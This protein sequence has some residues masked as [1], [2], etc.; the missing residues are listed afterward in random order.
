MN[1]KPF[2]NDKTLW[3]DFLLELSDRKLACY[4]KLEQLTDPVDIYRTQGE[5]QAISKLEQLRDKVNSNKVT[6][7]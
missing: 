4:K 1:L 2:V 6:T 5:I 3:Q 7:K